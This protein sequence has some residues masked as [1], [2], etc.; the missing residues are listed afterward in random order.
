MRDNRPKL[1]Q[2]ILLIPGNIR[3][4]I[5]L[6]ALII[7][8]IV[9]Q[10]PGLVYFLVLILL[11]LILTSLAN[12]ENYTSV[13][14]DKCTPRSIPE[15]KFERTISQLT[16]EITEIEKL[17]F[18]EIDRF[19]LKRNYDIIIVI[20]RDRQQ[21]IDWYLISFA[22]K[23]IF[24]ELTTV[25][26]SDLFIFTVSIDA[27]H[28]LKPKNV[29]Y[30]ALLNANYATLL[31]AH[32][33]ALTLFRQRGHHPKE[34]SPNSIRSHFVETERRENRYLMSIPFWA[35]KVTFWTLF[36]TGKKYRQPLSDQL[37]LEIIKIP[38]NK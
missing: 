35:I 20:L 28:T 13:F 34:I 22:N 26:E 23:I 17:G 10:P 36:K 30:Q 8:G 38:I 11:F 37:E 21:S 15:R 1:L 19:Y 2:P 14:L 5:A 29:Y 33:E 27:V 32:Q 24:S 12:Y 31:E 9:F 4:Y 6:A 16:K 18:R 7:W 25:F 3:L